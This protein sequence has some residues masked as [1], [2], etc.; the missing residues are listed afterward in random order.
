MSLWMGLVGQTKDLSD[1]EGDRLAGRK[2]GPIAWGEQ[3][4]RVAYSVAALL[5]GA[6]FTLYALIAATNL[7]AP[8]FIMAVGAVAVAAL[9]LGSWGKGKKE[10]RRRPYTAFMVT[11]YAANAVVVFF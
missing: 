4:A 3:R 5:M 7:V 1:V 2:S 9:T 8:A 10:S 11:Q 6:A